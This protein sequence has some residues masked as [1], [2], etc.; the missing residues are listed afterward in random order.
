MNDKDPISI[1]PENSIQN[2]SKN[3]VEKPIREYSIK[4]QTK[5]NYSEIVNRLWYSSEVIMIDGNRCADPIDVVND[6][7]HRKN[8]HPDTVKT[9]SFALLWDFS[10]KIDI[11]AF[12]DA[13]THLRMLMEKAKVLSKGEIEFKSDKP[14]P[15]RSMPK[16]DMEML[17]NALTDKNG[18]C[19][20][21]TSPSPR[22]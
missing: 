22:D 8:I 17:A 15:G 20:L 18:S 9:Y 12:A 2:L 7:Y 5:D 19:L 4:I 21:Y 11:K 10:K 6:L 16:E 1:A 14:K 13:V 3:P